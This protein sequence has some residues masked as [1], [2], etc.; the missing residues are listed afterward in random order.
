MNL[1]RAGVW[2]LTAIVSAEFIIAGLSKFRAG[3]TWPLMFVRW[4]FAPWF[5]PMVGAME[6]LCG[7]ALLLPRARP[8]ACSA[9][10]GIMVGAAATHLTHGE[11]GRV[12]LPIALAVLLGLLAWASRSSSCVRA[13]VVASHKS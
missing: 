13:T 6:V 9:L 3:S 11:T 5:R 7:A 8:W 4:G 12:I 2:A 10:I 1:K